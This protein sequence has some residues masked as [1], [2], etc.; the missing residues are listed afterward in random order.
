VAAA[1]AGRQRRPDRA[2]VLAALHQQLRELPAGTMVLAE[3]ET[4]V[5]LLPWMRST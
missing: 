2:Q 3:D 4:H 1:P 5:N